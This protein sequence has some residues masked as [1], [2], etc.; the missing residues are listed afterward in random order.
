MQHRSFPFRLSAKSISR[1][2]RRHATPRPAQAQSRNGDIIINNSQQNQSNSRGRAE[3]V[4]QIFNY[5]TGIRHR[6]IRSG[7]GN[8]RLQFEHSSL[9]PEQNT[10]ATIIETAYAFFS[11]NGSLR[12]YQL[13]D[14]QYPVFGTIQSSH[15]RYPSRRGVD[16]R[17]PRGPC[18]ASWML[19]TRLVSSTN[20]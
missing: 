7:R 19:T 1:R 14:V 13:L 20:P 5:E 10:T 15:L 8:V 11:T 16:R 3:E 4:I 2:N 9:S 17:H 12:E 6:I 18:M